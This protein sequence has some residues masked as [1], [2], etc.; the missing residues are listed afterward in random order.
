MTLNVAIEEQ[1]L[2]SDR[3]H[4]TLSCLFK[5]PLKNLFTSRIFTGS[6][7]WNYALLSCLR[8]TVAAK[9]LR[10]RLCSVLSVVHD[11]VCRHFR[12][13]TFTYSFKLRILSYLCVIVPAEFW[14]EDGCIHTRTKNI[15]CNS[16]KCVCSGRSILDLTKLGA[17]GLG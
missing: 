11:A 8:M 1:W 9:S 5:K 15:C 4:V 12:G 3:R 16:K 14:S 10:L 13:L 6:R 17:H 7:F 2:I